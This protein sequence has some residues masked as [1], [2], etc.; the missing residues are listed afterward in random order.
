MKKTVA[1]LLTSGT[2]L[3][4]G[5]GGGGGADGGHSSTLL[6]GGTSV[7]SPYL[8]TWQTACDGHERQVLEV[9]LKADGSGAFEFT[10]TTETY[11]EAGCGGALQGTESMSAA[12]SAAPDGIADILLKLPH[13]GSVT[14]VR[15]DK[16][17]L[18]IP[19]ITFHVAGAGVE[20]VLKDG[21]QQWCIGHD[22]GATCILDEGRRAA[23]SVA[24]G[25]LL[26]NNNL[27][28]VI[29]VGDDYVL[30]L[31]YVKK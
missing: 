9:A 25:L 28:T 22:G 2:A 3:L 13:S 29:K 12:I 15:I 7:Q 1:I 26:R 14:D 17:K 19:A 4:A 8:G 10:P 31:L 30:D 24:G 5:C 20:Y 18:A 27:Y 16:I 23:Q 6:S 21:Q 11:L